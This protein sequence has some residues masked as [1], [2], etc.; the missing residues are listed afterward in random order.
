MSR[1]SGLPAATAASCSRLARFLAWLEPEDVDFCKHTQ[2]P[3]SE[4]EHASRQKAT[5]EYLLFALALAVRKEFPP[6]FKPRFQD[7]SR[8]HLRDI[9]PLKHKASQKHKL[10]NEKPGAMDAY[11]LN[12]A[13][14]FA[15]AQLGIRLP[16]VAVVKQAHLR[17]TAFP[18]RVL[19][20]A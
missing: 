2:E 4:S 8:K 19:Q 16:S 7:A 11:L 5:P 3:C 12:H 18:N 13:N 14:G 17:T 15:L 20:A 9:V 10:K 1:C 6:V